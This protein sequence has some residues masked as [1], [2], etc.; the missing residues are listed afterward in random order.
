MTDFSTLIWWAL[1]GVAL[2]VAAFLLYMEYGA[3][4]LRT[5]VVPVPGGLRFVAHAF[6]VE[7]LPTAR[8]LKVSASSNAR[9]Q[10]EHPML[11]DKDEK[12]APLDVTLPLAGLSIDVAKLSL[13]SR[14]EGAESQPTGFCRILLRSSDER[15]AALQGRSAGAKAELRLDRVPERVAAEFQ[16]FAGGVRFAVDKVEQ[17][18][19][20]QAAAQQPTPQAAA[21]GEDAQGDAT[22]APPEAAPVDP[23]AR[24]EAQ[25]AQW[26]TAAGFTGTFTE[27]GLDEVG[28]IAWL[29]DLDA[30]GGQAILHASQRTFYGSLKGASVT[31]LGADVEIGV[32]DAYWTKEEPRL[33][34]FR[35]LSGTPVDNHRL[36]KQRLGTAI[37]SLGG[38]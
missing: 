36:W 33:M 30:A 29:I 16:R 25:L 24:A 22:A 19:L 8:E 12:T 20:A 27:Y 34:T 1:G 9:Y 6:S 3:R 4:K 28:R 21:E 31:L 23:K 35:M 15:L 13:K 18:L 10:R 37:D 14:E 38:D 17:Q 5:R 11:G 7:S 2:F 26:R 32:R